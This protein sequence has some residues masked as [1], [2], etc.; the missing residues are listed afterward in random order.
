MQLMCLSD[1]RF[2]GF[3]IFL[4]LFS[5]FE[6]SYTIPNLAHK[7]WFPKHSQQNDKDCSSFV[8]TDY[9]LFKVH[10]YPSKSKEKLPY[11]VEVHSLNQSR[12]SPVP[13]GHCG[14]CLAVVL[15]DK[16]QSTLNLLWLSCSWRKMYCLVAATAYGFVS[17]WHRY[18]VSIHRILSW[19]VSLLLCNELLWLF[20]GHLKP[21]EG[22]GISRVPWKFL[23][24]GQRVLLLKTRKQVHTM[25]FLSGQ[26]V[27]IGSQTR[28]APLLINSVSRSTI[29]CSLA[30]S[31]IYP[32]SLEHITQTQ[33]LSPKGKGVE[34]K[35]QSKT[36]HSPPLPN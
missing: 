34:R 10:H 27:S 15:Y 1:I 4:I 13:K 14:S 21:A 6:G 11:K 23:Q 25:S 7:A 22:K 36:L 12:E 16:D 20:Q 24:M 8:H 18:A 29:S 35:G 19:G 30:P 5:G 31:C 17:P 26:A 2:A 28:A 9:N 33:S 32:L 3:S